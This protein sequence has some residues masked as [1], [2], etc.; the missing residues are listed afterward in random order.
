M[1]LLVS[2]A[3]NIT[4][5]AS[6]TTMINIIQAT[7]IIGPNYAHQIMNFNNQTV[8]DKLPSEMLHLVGAHWYN[9]FI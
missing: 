5:R 7:S 6:T 3:S 8:A 9:I 2:D 4:I 1:D